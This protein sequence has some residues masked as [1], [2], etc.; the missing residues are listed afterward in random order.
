MFP[1]TE[2][3]DGLIVSRKA[4]EQYWSAYCGSEDLDDDPCAV[5]LRAPSLNGLPPA[6]VVLAGCDLLRDEGRAYATRL[7]EEGVEVEEVCYAGQPHGFVNFGF[8]AAERA[9][10]HIGRWLRTRFSHDG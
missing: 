5:P 3:F 2:Q 7:R 6:L 1:S 4:T 10:E 9:F 8:P